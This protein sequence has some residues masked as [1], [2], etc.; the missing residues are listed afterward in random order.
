MAYVAKVE[1][2]IEVQRTRKTHNMTELRCC[3]RR[4]RPSELWM[5]RSY[6]LPSSGMQDNKIAENN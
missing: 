2:E 3:D 4:Y 1:I 5:L 6:I